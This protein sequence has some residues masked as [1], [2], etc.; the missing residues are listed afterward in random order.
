MHGIVSLLDDS[1]YQQV[2]EIWA[3]LKQELGVSGVYTT[4]FP[5]FSYHV[6]EHY[7]LER[8]KPIVSQL[9]NQTAPFQV[10]TSGLGVFTG[11]LNPVLYVNVVRSPQ[12]SHIQQLVWPALTPSSSGIVTYYHPDQWVPHI[13]LGYGDITPE[14]L[15]EAIRLLQRWSFTWQISVNNF[16]LLYTEDNSHQDQ[17]YFRANFGA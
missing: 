5:H 17:L 12:L 15:P 13:T 3:A 16:S 8:L 4:P 1:H 9:A 10:Q 2:I 11:G 6:A 7:D 14:N